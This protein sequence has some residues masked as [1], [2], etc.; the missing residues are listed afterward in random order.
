M[1]REHMGFL[2]TEVCV[3]AEAVKQ[4]QSIRQE[5]CSDWSSCGS[6]CWLQNGRGEEEDAGCQLFGTCWER[7]WW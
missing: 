3:L 5:T 4:T 7:H 6:I 2:L 1:G